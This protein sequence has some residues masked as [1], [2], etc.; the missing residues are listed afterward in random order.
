M[1]KKDAE[2]EIGSFWKRIS[3]ERTIEC[4]EFYPSQKDIYSSPQTKGLCQNH[5]QSL[6]CVSYS[7][8]GTGL[9]TGSHLRNLM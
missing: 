4:K 6:M 1:A 7:L 8:R 5:L 9:L 3:L 2:L